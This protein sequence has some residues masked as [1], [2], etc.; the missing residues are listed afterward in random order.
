MKGITKVSICIALLVLCMVFAVW[1]LF[2]RASNPAPTPTQ[3]VLL[4]HSG[5]ETPDNSH[6]SFDF[7]NNARS[8]IVCPDSWSLE[9]QDG[10]RANLSLA[11]LGDIRVSPRS[12]NTVSIPK[13][14]S[15]KPWRL[16]A[17]YYEED[18]VFDVKVGIDGSP[19]KQHLPSSASTV[20]GK[21]VVSD[22]VN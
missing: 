19:L 11:P 4:R 1:M 3:V 22:W 17:D 15:V 5:G 6:L 16:R 10:T 13:P 21:F 2:D 14:R 18:I 12:T 9:F 20:H 7:V 8:P